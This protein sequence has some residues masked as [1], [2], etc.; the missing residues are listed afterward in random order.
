MKIVHISNYFNDYIGYHENILPKYHKLLGHDVCL[1]TSDRNYLQPVGD[2][3]QRDYKNKEGI[4]VKRIKTTYELKHRFVIFKN[5]YKS[6]EEEKPDYIFH[7]GIT[8]PSLF[9]VIRYKK[10]HPSVFVAADNHADLNI[11]ARNIIWKL[12]YYKN[13][14]RINLK[15]IINDID[16][17]FGVTP[18]RCFFAFLELG[19][20]KSKIRF[21]PQGCDINEA[22]KY[23]KLDENKK[24]HDYLN[25]IT[26]GKYVKDDK[27]LVDLINGLRNLPVKLRIFGTIKNDYL[28]NLIKKEKNVTFIGWQDREGIFKNYLNS[29]LAIWPKLHTTLIEDAM[30]VGLPVIL[31]YYGSTCHLIRGNGFY[32]FS[33]EGREINCIFRLLLENKELIEYFKKCAEKM[34]SIFS[35]YEIA[36]ESIDYYYDSSPKMLHNIFMND[37]LCK[38]E[39]RNWYKL[40]N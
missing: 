29:D 32:L 40:I 18:A 35:Y 10:D 26:G 5:L 11:S 15:K 39:N 1:I 31:R 23:K 33:D 19:V 25:I 27:G 28:S 9:T 12:L 7:H 38:F 14:L 17:V 8:Q 20:P 2:A 3:K 34:R 30:A 37:P 24:D 4:L 22:E 21:L 6:I 13:V 16:V 36:K